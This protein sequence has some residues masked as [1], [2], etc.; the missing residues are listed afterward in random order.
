M[1]SIQFIK[2]NLLVALLFGL[3]STLAT[4]LFFNRSMSPVETILSVLT[5]VLIYLVVMWFFG[6]PTANQPRSQIDQIT[7]SSLPAD[8]QC[9]QSAST[10]DQSG[11]C[12]DSSCAPQGSTAPS[13]QIV[14]PANTPDADGCYQ[15]AYKT[16]QGL[17]CAQVLRAGYN[18]M[19]EPYT[20]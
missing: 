14:S 3:V 15:N 8:Q 11:A 7:Y 2:N 19:V 17:D 5:G 20:L 6:A 13:D 10:A 4:Y 16:H 12:A 18:E 1:C 9:D